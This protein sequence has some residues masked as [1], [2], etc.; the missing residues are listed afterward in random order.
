MDKYKLLKHG[1]TSGC[2]IEYRLLCHWA[3]IFGKCDEFLCGRNWRY[4][5]AG[6]HRCVSFM[7]NVTFTCFTNT[8]KYY[9]SIV[10]WLLLCLI[11]GG[12]TEHRYIPKGCLSEPIMPQLSVLITGWSICVLLVGNRFVLPDWFKIQPKNNNNAPDCPKVVQTLAS[13]SWKKKLTLVL[14]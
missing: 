5:S 11:P 14:R 9:G 13:F 2:G 3:P 8:Y 7:V 1:T 6:L 12:R 10:Y 4:S